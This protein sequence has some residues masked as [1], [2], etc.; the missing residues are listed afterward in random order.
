LR[1]NF[2]H[3]VWKATAYNFRLNFALIATIIA[4]IVVLNIAL[5]FWRPGTNRSVGSSIGG[6]F[7]AIAVHATILKGKSG[8]AAIASSND[9]L[10]PFLFRAA[11]FAI[12]VLVISLKALSA[13]RD[14]DP[15]YILVIVVLGCAFMEAVLLSTWGTCLPAVIIGADGSF[16]AAGA[17]GSKVFTY[18]LLRLI[19]CNGTL[20]AVAYI[21]WYMARVILESDGLMWSEENG[22]SVAVFA[23]Q[24][25]FFTIF[26]FQTVMLAT[27]LSRAFLIA[28]AKLPKAQPI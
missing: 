6:T 2:H 28:E 8:F 20:M 7:I 16:A 18:T 1:L 10:L 24:I 4:S 27:V 12:V 26:A 3:G 23:A 9:A 5:E 19:F 25:V 13:I 17:R 14:T 22:F 21:F 15:N 11:A